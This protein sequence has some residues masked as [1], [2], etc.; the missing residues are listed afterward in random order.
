M[1]IRIYSYPDNA[2]LAK[3]SPFFGD[4]VN[5]TLLALAATN[6]EINGTYNK[7]AIVYMDGAPE[8]QSTNLCERVSL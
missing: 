8:T 1:Y 3:I 4:P 7:I 6:L 5:V 2:T